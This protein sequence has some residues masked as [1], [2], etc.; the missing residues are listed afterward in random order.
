MFTQNGLV[1]YNKNQESL[2]LQILNKNVQE[3]PRKIALKA[4][5]LLKLNPEFKKF[6]DQTISFKD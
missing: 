6:N 2:F 3:N 1:F 4:L 5:Q